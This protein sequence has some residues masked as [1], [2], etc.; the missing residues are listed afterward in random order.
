[1]SQ[2]QKRFQK[3]LNGLKKKIPITVKNENESIS[4]RIMGRRFQFIF[5]KDYPF[6][7]PR[8]L[9]N[10]EDLKRIE[11]KKT[12]LK[13]FQNKYGKCGCYCC[14]SR[15]LT[16]EWS[17]CLKLMD[18]FEKIKRLENEWFFLSLVIV[19]DNFPDIPGDVQYL[20]SEFL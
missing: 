14:F 8:I 6:K 17:P 5:S 2:L 3:E 13:E 19:Q 16:D 1:M 7:P 20:I 15:I 9:R 11:V 18:I 4:F 12:L 10:G